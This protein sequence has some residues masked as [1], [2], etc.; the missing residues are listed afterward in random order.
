MWRLSCVTSETYPGNLLITFNA[1]ANGNRITA[2][3]WQ[4]RLQASTAASTGARNVTPT[5]TE[6]DGHFTTASGTTTNN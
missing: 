4:L 2:L 6:G 3:I 1:S 5:R